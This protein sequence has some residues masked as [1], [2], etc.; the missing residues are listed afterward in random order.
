MP[1][2]TGSSTAGFEHYGDYLYADTVLWA[3]NGW[4]DY[5]M[6]QTYWARNHSIASYTKLLDWWDKVFR[7]LNCNL[8]SGIGVYMADSSNTYDWYNNMYEMDGQLSLID[9]KA[10]VRGYSIYSYKHL[11]Y[12]YTGSTSKS[13]QQIRNAYSTAARKQL[14]FHRQ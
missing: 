3:K 12:G 9:T 2:T 1:I 7:N 4:I 13:A 11:K 8:Y 5:L 10:D 6:P 14:K